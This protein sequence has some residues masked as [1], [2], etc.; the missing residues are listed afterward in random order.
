MRKKWSKFSSNKLLMRSEF[1]DEKKKLRGKVY[2]YDKESKVVRSLSVFSLTL[3]VFVA[4]D[5]KSMWRVGE[6]VFFFVLSEQRGGLD[7]NSQNQSYTLSR[8][9]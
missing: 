7:I 9:K 4:G 3:S 6:V 8:E 2:V 5:K 1:A